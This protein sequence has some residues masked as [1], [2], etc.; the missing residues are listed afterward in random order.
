MNVAERYPSFLQMATFTKAWE[1]HALTDDDLKALEDEILLNP[2]AGK[3][4]QQRK[5][6]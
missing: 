2:I 1:Y 4:I 3:V 6:Q 5:T